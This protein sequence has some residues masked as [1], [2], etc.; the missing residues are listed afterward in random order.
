MAL[1]PR[2]DPLRRAVAAAREETPD[3][4]LE[5][6]RSVMS[7]VRAL[8]SPSDPVLTFGADGDPVRD[9]EGSR[10]YVA[11]RVV[12]AALRRRLQGVP[13]HAPDKI[14]LRVEDDRLVGVELG[15]VC[16][17]G[18]DLL[19]VAER[20]REDVLAELLG[21]V[22]PDPGLTMASIDISIDDVVAGDPNVV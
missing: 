5:I 18:V 7:R 21:L 6:S 19:A 20:L 22:G 3:G 1:E 11:A 4:W 13:T 15:L 16:A 2:T 12:Q 10:T 9:A 17:Y 14:V 8:V